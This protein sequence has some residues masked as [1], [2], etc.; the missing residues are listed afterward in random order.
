MK[1]C[2]LLARNYNVF[3]LIQL[4]LYIMQTE[5]PTRERIYSFDLANDI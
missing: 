1:L 5:I 3:L 4:S 2:Q